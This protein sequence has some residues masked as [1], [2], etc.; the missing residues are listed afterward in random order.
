M[1]NDRV[2]VTATVTV[3]TPLHL[4]SGED[5]A[6]IFKD[7][8]VLVGQVARD[9][10]GLPCLP[11]SSVK[12]L[13]RRLADPADRDALFG[14]SHGDTGT[15]GRIFVRM[16]PHIGDIPDMTHLPQRGDR[17]HGIFV[18]ARTR[19][20]RATGTADDGLLYHQEMIAP[21]MRFEL[22]LSLM[23][24]ADK[25]AL[26]T[27]LSRLAASDGAALGGGQADG[28]GRVR[29]VG[30]VVAKRL[31]GEAKE[32]QVTA[33]E[34]EKPF[35]TLKLHCRGPYIA[36]DASRSKERPK[37]ED[38]IDESTK[39]D[40]HLLP[41]CE[42]D[43]RPALRG[44]ALTGAL[45]ARAAWLQACKTGK[46]PSEV[47]DPDKIHGKTAPPS[48]V[49]TLFGI[50]G[51][52]GRLQVRAIHAEDGAKPV[53]LTSLAVDQFSAAP[54]DNALFTTQAY[55]DCRFT[56]LLDLHEKAGDEAQ[57]VLRDLLT[58]CQQNGLMLGHGGAKGFGWFTVEADYA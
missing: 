46:S 55:A 35:V 2:D 20:D 47:D 42:A 32:W 3:L 26:I 22:R 37:A 6:E 52:R 23:D 53:R 39:K 43:G 7:R 36:V 38:K 58:D 45:R 10:R 8:S 4:G 44:S 57:A 19:I 54:I 21:D 17:V 34:Q 5:K 14:T 25:A 27:I 31:N 13:L 29:L 51:L 40:P 1:F 12:G 48:P 41:L 24:P 28:M 30:P 50:P 15:A 9:H 56:I 16:A 49:E 18:E 33:A 11:G